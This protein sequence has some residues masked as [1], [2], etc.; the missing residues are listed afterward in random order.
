MITTLSPIDQLDYVLNFLATSDLAKEPLTTIKILVEFRD[1][2][3]LE[4][5]AGDLN[6]ILDKLVDERYIHKKTVDDIPYYLKDSQP[7]SFSDMYSI[8]FDGKLF[9]QIGGYKEKYRKDNLEAANIRS[10]LALR[11]RNDRLLAIGTVGVAIGALALVAWEI[12][13]YFVLGCH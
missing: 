8:T 5:Q 3:D 2:H 7:P 6:R 12:Y 9:N 4:F 10:D 1:K 13:K 11:K